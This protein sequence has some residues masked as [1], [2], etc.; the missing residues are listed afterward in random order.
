MRRAPSRAATDVGSPLKLPPGRARSGRDGGAAGLVGLLGRRDVRRAPP[1]QPRPG[2]E[3][4]AGA[5]LVVEQ[6][7]P[8]EVI[9]IDELAWLTAYHPDKRIRDRVKNRRWRR[10]D[11]PDPDGPRLTE[12]AEERDD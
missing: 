3:A 7:E 4:E 6:A 8:F 10:A 1:A 2:D 11:H 5:A 12:S 9:V